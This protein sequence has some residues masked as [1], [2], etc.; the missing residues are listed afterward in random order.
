MGLIQ[1][2]VHV[3]GGVE[4]DAQETP[5]PGCVGLDGEERERQ[6]AHVF[7]H[8]QLPILLADE[9]T[10]IRGKLHGRGVGEAR[11][12]NEFRKTRGERRGEARRGEKQPPCSADCPQ[13]AT[14][15]VVLESTAMVRAHDSLRS[16]PIAC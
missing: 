5:L 8:A 7:D 13:G 15:S 1:V 10:P 6:E 9:Q 14:T 4:R 11:C 3:E 12:D 2:I 16:S